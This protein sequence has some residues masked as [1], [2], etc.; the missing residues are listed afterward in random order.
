MSLNSIIA[1]AAG[2]VL[3]YPLVGV[4]GTGTDAFVAGQSSWGAIVESLSGPLV[5]PMAAWLVLGCVVG[6]GAS[7]LVRGLRCSRGLVAGAIGGLVAAG[8]FFLEVQKL[9]ETWAHLLAAAILGLSM[10][11]VILRARAGMGA[12]DGNAPEAKKQATASPA[13]TAKDQ[14]ASMPDPGPKPP[15]KAQSSPTPPRDSEPA[16]ADE[17]VSEP[18]HQVQAAAQGDSAPD[19]ED[20]DESQ[21]TPEDAS[22]AAPANKPSVPALKTNAKPIA[23][24]KKSA[25]PLPQK[26]K[27]IVG[28]PASGSSGWMQ[29][30]L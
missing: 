6:I 18:K 4:S 13:P 30:H 2:E 23:T 16:P 11:L 1:L 17:S 21:K 19:D 27:P 3:S 24:K 10:A 7:F 5:I 8:V 14:S 22:K 15:S 12:A 9:G 28:K 29:D 26:A 20:E 25:P